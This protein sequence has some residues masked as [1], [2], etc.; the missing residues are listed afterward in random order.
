MA[1]QLRRCLLN[2][3]QRTAVQKI[4]ADTARLFFHIPQRCFR[5]AQVIIY[6]QTADLQL[7]G[8]LC[9]RKVLIVLKIE[10]H[11]LTLG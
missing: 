2:G 9:K 5:T 8:N 7:L 1:L 3:A 4:S 10:T 11:S 6:T